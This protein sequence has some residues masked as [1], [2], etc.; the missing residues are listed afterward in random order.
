MA[1]VITT[2]SIAT[3]AADAAASAVLLAGQAARDCLTEARLTPDSV[4]ALINV[5]VYREHNMFEPAIG[6]MVQKE[7]G[8]NL[9]YLA[10]QAPGISSFSF[11]L[12]NGACGVLNAVQV[13]QAILRTGSTERVLI[14]AA[15]VH[16]GGLAAL[17]DQYPY[18]D[19]GGALLLERSATGEGGFGAVRVAGSAGAPT[20]AGYLRTAGMGTAGRTQITVRRDEGFVEHL[21]DLAARTAVE[22]ATTEGLDLDRTV[23]IS[24]R[25]TP[26][27]AGRLA[28]RLGLPQSQVLAPDVPAGGETPGTPNSHTG[29]PHTAAPILGYL[30]A[31]RQGLPDQLLFVA[32][33]T[34][35]SIACASYRPQETS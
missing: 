19:L 7:A 1:T 25:P 17:D 29:L 5:G 13:A 26:D 16:P 24:S 14:T 12:M 31:L 34:G 15:D 3:A 21:L 28:E 23:L 30:S 11:D 2:A 33:G 6:A 32:A 4:G 35:P 8:L 22:Y 10:Q 9:D 27:F 18:A 20:A